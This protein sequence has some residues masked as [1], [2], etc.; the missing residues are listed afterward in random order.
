[1]P[2]QARTVPLTGYNPSNPS[3]GAGGR[4]RE[5]VIMGNVDKMAGGGG[6]ATAAP[7]HPAATTA[8]ASAPKPSS[9]APRAVDG[10]ATRVYGSPIEGNAASK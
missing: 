7:V 2:D 8:A 5:S 3:S 10:N 6:K 1:M 4:T 9:F